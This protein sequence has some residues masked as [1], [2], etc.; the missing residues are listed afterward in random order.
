MEADIITPSLL[1]H[2]GLNHD[3]QKLGKYKTLNYQPL[4]IYRTASVLYKVIDSIRSKWGGIDSFLIREG[5]GFNIVLN[6]P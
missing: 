4:T 3:K 2:S 1:V 6:I 5:T